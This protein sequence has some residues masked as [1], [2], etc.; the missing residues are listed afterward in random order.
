MIKCL[1]DGKRG[2]IQ[3]TKRKKSQWNDLSISAW[4]KKLMPKAPRILGSYREYRVS[5]QDWLSQ[6][7]FKLKKRM[8]GWGIF[9][10]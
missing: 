7:R 1:E 6:L 2:F 10:S 4:K 5:I 3:S 9:T 8:N